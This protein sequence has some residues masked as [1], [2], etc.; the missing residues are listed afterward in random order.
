MRAFFKLRLYSESVPTTW[1]GDVE[2]L[3]RRHSQLLGTRGASFNDQRLALGSG[4][5]WVFFRN[6]IPDAT[7]REGICKS[8]VRHASPSVS[9][10]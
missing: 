7:A 8:A 9:Q 10:M 2:Q 5:L 4:R 1:A 6:P 3:S